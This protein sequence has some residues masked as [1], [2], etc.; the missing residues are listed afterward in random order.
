M[1]SLFAWDKHSHSECIG[2]HFVLW[3][4]LFLYIYLFSVFEEVLQ[5]CKCFC[6]N[7]KSNG[8]T[9]HPSTLL[10]PC[11]YCKNT[12]SSWMIM[13]EF[14]LYSA[15]VF[16]GGGWG[17]CNY[18]GH[19]GS[20]SVPEHFSTSGNSAGLPG[21]AKNVLPTYRSKST[22]NVLEAARIKRIFHLGQRFESNI[23]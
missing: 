12:C 17:A 23:N 7:P 18:F 2:L 13:H 15:I 10:P 20:R 16:K 6:N 9:R 5:R 1:K 8:K 3:T 21:P 11:F 4:L 19:G 14:I 22:Q